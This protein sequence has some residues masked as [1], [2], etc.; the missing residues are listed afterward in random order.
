MDQ[1]VSQKALK[2]LSRPATNSFA[3]LSGRLLVLTIGFVMLA[4]V[5]I[6]L[7]TMARYRISYFEA[8]IEL[9][10]QAALALLAAPDGMVSE[11]LE[12]ELLRNVGAKLVAMRRA[13]SNALILSDRQEL[14]MLGPPVDLSNWMWGGA[15]VHAVRALVG[16]TP[17]YI[18]VVGPSPRDAQTKIEVVLPAAPLTEA[19]RAFS[20]RIFTMSLGISIFTASLVY[21]TLQWWLVRP[22]RRLVDSIVGFRAAP[23]D[24]RQ[25]IQPSQRND[26]LGLAERELQAMQQELR[27]ALTQRARL[28][29]L[30]IAVSKISHDL[31]NI[32]ASAQLVSDRLATS[33][34][35]TVKQ[36]TPR[37]VGSIDRAIALCAQTLRYGKAE[38]R[39]PEAEYFALYPFAEDVAAG[40]A[41]PDEPSIR[42]HNAVPED[43]QVFADREHL[44]RILNNIIRNAA[45]AMPDGGDIRI[46]AANRA[47]LTVIEI[48]DTGCGLSEAV[49]AHLFEPFRGSRNGGTGLG[50]AIARELA[51]AHGGDLELARTGPLGTTFRITLPDPQKNRPAKH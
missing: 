39:A 21:L 29:Q 10:D 14:P 28:A 40:L 19:L 5:L 41:L 4:E 22:M 25:I 6:Y 33:E 34:D 50:L 17:D 48:A 9:A 18:R 12:N 23:E 8:R 15:I 1:A 2:R 36:I 11:E 24:A 26:E 43:L 35:P 37:L 32:L 30:G 3:G 38:E 31:R 45:Q 20:W 7:P 46:A 42:W 49:Q 27:Q 16:D 44:Y 13:A 47:G 51:R